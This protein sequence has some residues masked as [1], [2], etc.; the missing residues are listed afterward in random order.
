MSSHR[1][2][3]G[4]GRWTRPNRTPVN[5]RI[6]VECGVVEDEYHFVIEC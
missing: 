1:L 4:S 6:C 5:E 3:I 2:A